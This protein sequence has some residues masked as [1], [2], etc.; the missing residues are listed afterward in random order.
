MQ[1]NTNYDTS[2]WVWRKC[3]LCGKDVHPLQQTRAAPLSDGIACV[4]C[5]FNRVDAT[6]RNN[7]IPS[8]KVTEKNRD[9]RWETRI[10]ADS[11]EKRQK[12]EV[13]DKESSSAQ[14]SL[15]EAMP[16]VIPTS[17]GRT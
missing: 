5:A 12:R 14:L 10:V 15:F 8:R 13:S 2:K 16:E 7:G 9:G 3:A 4:S 1:Y 6:R 17:D 11:V